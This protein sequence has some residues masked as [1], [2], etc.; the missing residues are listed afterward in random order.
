MAAVSLAAVVAA[1]ACGELAALV[2]P[3]RLK[4]EHLEPQ[5]TPQTSI[6]F[7][8][9]GQTITELHAEK[10]RTVVSLEDVP[11]HARRAIIAVEDRRFYDHDGI[12]LM[13]IIRAAAANLERGGVV[14]GGSTITQQL[15]KN[16]IIAPGNER[17]ALSLERKI[18]EAALSRQLERELTKDEIL[19]R[20]LNTVYFGNGAYG[21]EAA[22][23]NYF[24]KSASELNLR[25][26]A[27][28]AGLIR[29]PQRYDPFEHR[30]RARERRNF[31]LSRMADIGYI[32]ERRRRNASRRNLALHRD[33][34]PNRYPAPYF[35][36]YVQRLLTFHPRFDMLGDTI[37]ERVDRIFKG[38]LEI[39]TTVRLPMQR[40]AERAI[41]SVL[42]ERRDPHAALVAMEPGTGEIW[43]MVGG[44]DFFA[45]DQQDR[46]ARL[47]LAIPAARNLGRSNNGEVRAPGTG[48]QAGSAFK[49][50][51]LVAAL[52]RGRSLQER[53]PGQSCRTFAGADAGGD[54]RVCNFG[55]SSFGNEVSLLQA[56]TNS[57]N[58][59]YARL[60]LDVGADRVVET[61]RDMGIRSIDLAPVNSAAL[62][63]NPVN[64]LDMAAAYG[65][66]AANGRYHRPV[67]I[68]KI[69]DST[70]DE[71]I[72]REESSPQRVVE[73]GAA[74]VTT[75]ALQEAMDRG[76]GTG[77]RI[78]RPAAGKTGTAQ[79][80]RD[81]WFVGYTPQLVTAVWI[82]YPR[83]SVDMRVSCP[84]E[85]RRACRPTRI[86][87][88]GGSWP[89]M[90]WQAFM[91][92]AM[93]GLPARDFRRP[94][95]LV[96]V[97]VDSRHGC[98]AG[99]HT[100][101]RYRTRAVFTEGSEPTLTCP[102]PSR[103]D[104]RDVEEEEGDEDEA[105]ER[106]GRPGNN[107]GR[108]RGRGRN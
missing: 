85:D 89:A 70:K 43:A 23:R 67:A 76:T 93:E 11:R 57:I 2:D 103:P 68:T 101:D 105:G 33:P 98:L 17:A 3:A 1:A 38:G 53:L 42:T 29:A 28:L 91:A 108:G 50:F 84:T 49:T 71:V 73:P 95:G 35:V 20:Y 32:N 47:N 64:A 97:V 4:P 96:E 8:R 56:T 7:G 21:I 12:D 87:V 14:E 75:R 25:E 65:T 40:R 10:D 48:R 79:G 94:D 34:S 106:N 22:A 13:G 63:T 37:A 41:E 74:Y 30:G 81:A 69:V 45:G 44:R 80:F 107:R 59:A 60:I 92:S 6:V 102:A 90:I 78:G 27:L 5:L 62:G 55:R 82:G 16:T 52:E 72:F 66:L 77:A 31:V 15:V 104:D 99:S 54:W 100:P 86:N 61:A 18:D 46:F 19:E 83:A 51:A 58:V 39:H 88:T 36:D 24:A 9:G 26:S